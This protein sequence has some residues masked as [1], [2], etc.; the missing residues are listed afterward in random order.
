MSVASAV[1]GRG[2]AA[3]LLAAWGALA[4]PMLFGQTLWFR[5][6][7]IYTYPQKS[8]VL[9]RLLRAELPWWCERWGTGRP[10]FAMV[11][12]GVFDPLNALLLLP[13]PL[14]L[15][16]FNLAH[17]LVMMF[18]ARA[19]LRA[20]RG[21]ELDAS[22]GALMLG[23]SGYVASMFASNG[24]YAWGVSYV[25]WCL[26]AVTAAG[27]ARSMRDALLPTVGVAVSVALGVLSGDPMSALFAGVCGLATALAQEDGAARRRAVLALAGGGAVAGLLC[28]VQLL[29]AVAFAR[30]YRGEGV[31]LRNAE[32][33]SLHPRRAFELVLPDALGA[34]FSAAWDVPTLYTRSAQQRLIPFAFSVHQGVLLLPLAAL[35]VWRRARLDLALLAL[36]LCALVLALGR[37]AP[38]WPWLFMHVPGVS[39]FRHPEKYAFVSSLA[40]AALAARGVG[41]A[42][43]S[44]R[45]AALLSLTLCALSLVAWRLLPASGALRG[46]AWLLGYAATFGVVASAR[47]PARASAALPLAV[48]ACELVTGA[49]PIF[50]W[51]PAREVYAPPPLLR[52]LAADHG[53]DARG[54]LVFRDLLMRVRSDEMDPLSAVGTLM[55]NLATRDGVRFLDSYDA[56]K[57]S[58]LRSLRR[59]VA[60]A[61]GLLRA[62]GVG[63]LVLPLG[64]PVP[65]GAVAVA[66]DEVRGARLARVQGPAPRV[67]L[68]RETV[69]VAGVADA[70]RAMEAAGFVA[71]QS[72]AVEG[73]PRVA[74]GRCA[75]RRESPERRVF[76]CESDAP[77]WMHV[78]ESFDPGWRA[79]V[80]GAPARVARSNELFMAVAVPAG[81]S[82]VVMSL[83]PTGLRAG[84]A[85]SALG[86][87]LVIGAISAARRER[88]RRGGARGSSP[89]THGGGTAP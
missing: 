52:A 88:R 44:P 56:V 45:V 81:A 10:F 36:A 31:S 25:P 69:R 3:L 7:L 37:F 4:A 28:A 53:G 21:E 49:L 13:H 15:D 20:S 75:V 79:E 85:L 11:Q 23:L 65:P 74:R 43:R 72:A 73:E 89:H 30:E 67:Y 19:W 35:A 55:P 26:A 16:A 63:Y 17:L 57:V 68:A 34:P 32:T 38:V 70:L 8:Y 5:D 29:P 84:A 60:R 77:G 12:P 6:L 1:R 83:Q 87:V 24:T 27:G 41:E 58:R 42:R 64:A 82:T 76:S 39:M 71:G 14:N 61:P 40:L 86:V 59:E 78:G 18:G 48:L 46:A 80:N 22:A 51:A 33:F 9:E 47:L 50:R 2:G 62:W 66:A 54:A